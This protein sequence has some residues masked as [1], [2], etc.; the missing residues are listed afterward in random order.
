MSYSSTVA[1][2]SLL[3]FKNSS[4]I[5]AIRLVDIEN[6]LAKEFAQPPGP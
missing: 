6:I 2:Q 5:D 1:A 3:S 4:G